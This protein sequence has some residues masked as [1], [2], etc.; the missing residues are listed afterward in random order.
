MI[1]INKKIII[2]ID[3]EIMYMKNIGCIEINVG[4]WSKRN[5]DACKGL[6]KIHHPLAFRKKKKKK[7]KGRGGWHL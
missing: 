7:E 1:N 3:I 4:F 5:T 6:A 2:S